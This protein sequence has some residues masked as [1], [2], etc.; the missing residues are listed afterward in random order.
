MKELVKKTKESDSYK[1]TKERSAFAYRS[2][3]SSAKNAFNKLKK[4]KNAETLD[5]NKT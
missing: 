4:K 5:D 1:K 3:T 2:F